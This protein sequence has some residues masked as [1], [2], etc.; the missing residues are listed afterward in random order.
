MSNTKMTAT[1]RQKLA[2]L[3]KKAGDEGL[4]RVIRKEYDRQIQT[5]IYDTVNHT[6]RVLFENK[7]EG[8]DVMTARDIA[9]LL[10][11]DILAVR[12][13]TKSKAQKSS[14]HPIPFFKINGKMLRFSRPLIK[15]WLEELANE[16]P[17]FEGKKRRK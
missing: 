7:D 4:I 13:M 17:V 1:E 15:A 10:Q 3:M 11:T 5:K 16:K 14:E 8:N 9:V 6:V 2:K 12:E